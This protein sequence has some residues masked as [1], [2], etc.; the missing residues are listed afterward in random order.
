[1]PKSWQRVLLALLLIG[2]LTVAAALRL[3][4]INW[5][6]F[7]HVH[8][9]E[10]FIVWVADSMTR[11]ADLAS[12]FDPLRSTINPFRWPP[13]H[14]EEAGKPRSYAY[15]HVPLYLLVVVAHAAQAVGQWLG[16]TTL[17]LPAILQPLHTV[18][19]H[20]A[21]YNYL[22]LV[23]R[24]ISTLCDLGTLLLMYGLGRRVY[25]RIAGLLAAGAYAFAVLPIQLSHFYAV[26][27]VLTFC[28]VATV[29]LAAR[30]A[31]G[32]GWLAWI[33][34]S[35]FAG[36]AVGS[37]FSA[38]LIVAPL[39]A[40]TW[41]RAAD[42]SAR[43]RIV[44]AT[45]QLAVAGAAAALTFIVTNPFAV[46]E[47]RAYASN[48]LAQNA[49]V[50]GLMDAP[51]TRQYIGTLPYWYFVQQ[52][53]QWGLGWPL[54]LVAWGGFV[55]ALIRFGMRRA[56]RAE[57][58]ML[59]WALPYFALTGA[60]HAK[61]LRYMAPL[62][63]FLLIF[64]AGAALAA[65][66]WMASRW[67]RRGRI[68][69]GAAALIIAV[70]TV[71]W[72]SAFVGVYRQEHPWLQASRWIYNN[73]PE[74]SKLL[75]E[76]WDD[77]LPLRMD[78]I[79]GRPPLREYRRI[80]LPLYDADTSAKLDR[81]VDELGSADYLI[82][83]SNRLS[84]PISR[85]RER[86]PMTSSYYRLLE[87]GELGYTPA[88]EFVAYPQLLGLTIP[89]DHADESFTVYDHPRATIYRNTGR[90]SPELLRARLERF[91]PRTRVTG[92]G[93]QVEGGLSE[94]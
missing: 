75:T 54:G 27:V 86:Y 3:T 15:G 32:G 14:G 9:D 88:A 2:L 31:E 47:L 45:G 48:V 34:A 63:P 58:V 29:A 81:L 89:D 55:W 73:I 79:A 91:L 5:D 1:M 33:G 92:Y 37:K 80:E 59:A 35:I 21:E 46:I 42:G 85:L 12:T 30:R 8:P 69:W 87:S 84:A 53:S 56:G 38:I 26:D 66:R 25:G 23:G 7:Q 39:V 74:S 72:S 94:P 57:V 13:G 90:L 82:L 41:Y 83:A 11:P 4:N 22:A 17:A 6:Q 62:L 71:G 28:V 51:Y 43:R 36:L 52:L 61:F 24:A 40:A 60:F 70:A 18:G 49:M 78:E 19:R 77:A 50:S 20:L 64:G 65:Y 44:S 76:H 68:A 67:G 93:S 10:R 16:E